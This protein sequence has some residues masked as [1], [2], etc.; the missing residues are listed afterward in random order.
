MVVFAKLR[1]ARVGQLCAVIS[2]LVL[3]ACSSQPE[4][5][6]VPEQATNGSSGSS[7]Y[8]IGPGDQLSVFVWQD[9]ELSVEVPVRPDGRI[10]MPLIEDVVAAGK[11]P[12]ALARELETRLGAYVQEPLITVVVTEFVG[13]PNQ[14]VRVVGEAAEPASLPFRANMTALD[15][16]IAVGGLTE[17][18]DGNRATLVRI[19]GEETRSYRLRLDDLIERGDL[20]A[21]AALAPGDV[22]VV[23]QTFF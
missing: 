17:F 2:V 23:P 15:A 18:A 13:A 22:I 10:S 7:D 20:T 21:N 19:E 6:L 11:T 5:P 14:Q 12:T 4:A 16:I 1:F 3:A 8:V 9:S